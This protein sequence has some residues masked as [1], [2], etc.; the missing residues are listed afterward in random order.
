MAE[1]ITISASFSQNSRSLGRIGRVGE[2]VSRRILFDCTS[3]LVGRASATIACVIQH[4][5]C[6]DPYLAPIE[7]TDKKGVYSLTLR[8]VDVDC[9]CC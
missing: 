3:V 8:D 9:R 6:D 2:N 7:E 4:P 1:K 5:G